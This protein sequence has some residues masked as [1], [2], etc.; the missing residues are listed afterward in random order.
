MATKSK[1][2]RSPR[3]Q[4]RSW[5]KL[6]VTGE[7]AIELPKLTDDCLEYMRSR[8]QLLNAFMSKIVR[9]ILYEAIRDIFSES[10]DMVV[11]GNEAVSDREAGRRAQRLRSRWD[12]WLEHAGERFVPLKKMCRADLVLSIQ[13]RR[14]RGEHEHMLADWQQAL[15]DGL[16]DDTTTIGERFTDEEIEL[17]IRQAQQ[18][19]EAA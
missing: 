15:L 8:P 16:E 14:G 10:R 13:E 5:V 19:R 1:P 9:G 3:Q 18:S 7:D 4:I 6:R 17:A 12:R 2:E 11:L